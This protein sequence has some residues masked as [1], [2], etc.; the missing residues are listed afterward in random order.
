MHKS[1]EIKAQRSLQWWDLQK[2]LI[3]ILRGTQIK[4]LSRQNLRVDPKRWFFVTGDCAI[5]RV[6]AQTIPAPVRSQTTSDVG[7][8]TTG[9]TSRIPQ[10]TQKVIPKMEAVIF[11]TKQIT[12]NKQKSAKNKLSSNCSLDIFTF[13]VPPWMNFCAKLITGHFFTCSPNN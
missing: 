11:Q 6:S 9:S 4:R 1:F 5:I 2:R 12:K 3:Q 10:T 7:T 13:L 8:A